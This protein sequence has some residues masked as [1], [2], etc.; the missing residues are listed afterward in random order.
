MHEEEKTE[1]RKVVEEVKSVEKKEE[2]VEM[3]LVVDCIKL[4]VRSNPSK[5]AD[6][7]YTLKAGEEVMVCKKE[8]LWF[9]I[10]NAAGVAGYAMNK[11]LQLK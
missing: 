5:E 4:N 6:V 7:L 8:K 3:A 11:Y 2:C 1:V 9:H 10:H